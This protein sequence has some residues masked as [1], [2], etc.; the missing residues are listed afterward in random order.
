[1]IIIRREVLAFSSK[2]YRAAL[3]SFPRIQLILSQISLLHLALYNGLS[4]L[5]LSAL[6]EKEDSCL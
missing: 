5:I 3:G 2:S 4:L 6:F 1:M